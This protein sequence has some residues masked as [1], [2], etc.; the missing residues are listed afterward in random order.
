MRFKADPVLGYSVF[1]VQ[2]ADQGRPLALARTEADD[3][4]GTIPEITSSAT[5]PTLSTARNRSKAVAPGP[6]KS[7]FDLTGAGLEDED[8]EFQAALQASLLQAPLQENT[9]NSTNP[10]SVQTNPTRPSVLAND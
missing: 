6:S 3:A 1:V 7:A 9:S 4:A 8:F 5:R 2:Q 10:P